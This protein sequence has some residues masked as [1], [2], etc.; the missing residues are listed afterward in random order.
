MKKLVEN[1]IIN[2]VQISDN[3]YSFI[4]GIFISLATNIFTTLCFEEFILREQWNQYLSTIFFVIASGLCL[5]IS[6]KVNMI[7][8]FVRARKI[9]VTMKKR[10]IIRDII[11]NQSV[12]RWILIYVL[13]FVMI[14][15]GTIFLGLNFIM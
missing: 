8:E 5:C 12:L 14:I 1:G 15:C 13:L 10:E 3:A 11:Q 2:L 7:Q 6:T 9:S 4:G